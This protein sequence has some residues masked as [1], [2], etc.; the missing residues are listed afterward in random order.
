MEEYRVSTIKANEPDV[1]GYI[2][3]KEV[4]EKAVEQMNEKQIFIQLDYSSDGL[5]HIS[6]IAGFTVPG[7]A[8]LKDGQIFSTVKWVANEKGSHGREYIE[9]KACVMGGCWVGKY[10]G[11]RIGSDAVLR[12]IAVIMSP[13]NEGK[14][15]RL[16]GEENE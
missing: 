7:T 13:Q 4:L 6:N 14:Y 2:W 15:D 12:Y 1:N 9:A 5:V 10:E 16:G 8:V 11:N 3:P